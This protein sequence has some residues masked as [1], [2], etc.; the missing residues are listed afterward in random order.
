MNIKIRPA[1]AGLPLSPT[2]DANQSAQASTAGG[3]PLLH[4]GFGQSPFPVHPRLA[5]A[6]AA[7]ATRNAYDDV[8][9]LAELRD[10]AKTYFCARLGLDA[11]AYECVV[12][13]GSKL[14]LYALQMAIEGDLILPMPSW[15]SYAP[16]A[17]MLGDRVHWLPAELSNDGYHIDAD[18]LETLILEL[19]SRDANPRKLI[20]NSPNNPTGLVIPAADLGRIAA[21]C[22]HHGVFLISDEIYAL[23]AYDG[24]RQSIAAHCAGTAAVTTGLSKHLSLGGWRVGFGLVPANQ[25]SLLDSLNAIASETWSCVAAPVQ[26]AALLAVAGEN[27]IEDYIRR[28]TRIHAAVARVAAERIANAPVDCPRAQGAFYLWPNFEPMRQ[29]LKEKD[30]LASRQLADALLE[31]KRVLALPGSAFGAP[32][33]CLALRLSV[34]DYNGVEALA[35]CA[36]HEINPYQVAEFAPRVV[37]AADAIAEFVEQA[38][39]T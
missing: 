13:P 29:R 2:L 16:Q 26:E 27:D 4:M 25:R 1:I 10:R 5:D 9:G 32:P 12:A 31:Q 24:T 21:V 8:A 33:D 38:V 7:A 34:C 17:T 19:R 37:E 18:R 15:V 22:E 23:T 30:I 11:G 28:C 39:T 6:L 35:A 14:I 3:Q 20:L 36:E